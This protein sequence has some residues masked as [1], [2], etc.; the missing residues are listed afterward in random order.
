M[1]GQYRD[2]STPVNVHW[3]EGG[4]VPRDP[5]VR[6]QEKDGTLSVEVGGTEEQVRNVWRG[7]TKKYG[8]S[9]PSVDEALAN[10]TRTSDPSPW[11]EIA[12]TNQLPLLHKFA[13]KVALSGGAAIWGK[14][15]IATE[16]ADALRKILR[17]PEDAYQ[18]DAP[19]CDLKYL[20]TVASDARQVA[21][22]DLPEL[23]L[24]IP[25]PGA[26]PTSQVVF[27]A[28]PGEAEPRTGIFVTILNFPAPPYGILV[29]GE[30][31]EN[32]TLPV[33]L[34]EKLGE[35]AVTL[36]LDEIYFGAIASLSDEV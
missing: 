19:K 7:L 10:A 13:A 31:P 15:F 26:L 27:G 3:A 2:E 36:K 4:A 30:V 24:P 23:V 8:S 6:V 22:V 28:L 32:P 14:R 33:V 18:P 34:R 17:A 16:F 5:K 35:Q 20:S 11:V 29:P 25:G 1:R 12:L 21:P 9:I